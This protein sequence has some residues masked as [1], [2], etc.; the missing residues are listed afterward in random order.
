MGMTAYHG[1]VKNI[2]DTPFG[3]TLKLI[4]GKWKMVI[5]YLLS[6]NGCLR[7]N[8]LQRIIGSI[9]FRAL[10]NALKD[11]EADQLIIR[12]EYPQVP[13]KVEYKLSERG[14]TLIPVLEEL[15]WWGVQFFPEEMARLE[16]QKID[17]ERRKA[18]DLA[19][20]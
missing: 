11:L 17:Y 15:C 16:E 7:F 19:E 18:G 20:E 13:P 6:E 14:K 2:E 4:G 12:T 10:S 8:E 5:L 3:Y 9:T 1:V